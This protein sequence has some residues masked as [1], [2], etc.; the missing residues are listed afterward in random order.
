MKLFKKEK[1]INHQ[2]SESQQYSKRWK[3]YLLLLKAALGCFLEYYFLWTER[4]GEIQMV[5]T[6]K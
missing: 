4:W 1:P 6:L 2:A 5:I 3:K